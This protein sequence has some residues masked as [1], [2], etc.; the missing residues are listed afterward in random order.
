MVLLTRLARALAA[1]EGEGEI[2]PPYRRSEPNGDVG[3]SC[4]SDSGVWLATRGAPS[5]RAKRRPVLA[6]DA[7]PEL[8]A[9]GSQ[10]G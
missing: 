4:S 9:S 10:R 1:I 5:F 2:E 7:M 6:T 3:G 8:V